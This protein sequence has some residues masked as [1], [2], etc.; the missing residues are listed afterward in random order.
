MSV[1]LERLLSILAEEEQIRR[2]QQATEEA[3][4][5]ATASSLA[6]V[7]TVYQR[8]GLLA[9]VT[10]IW[11][12]PIPSTLIQCPLSSLPTTL[13]PWKSLSKPLQ[14]QLMASPSWVPPSSE[15][16][17][18]SSNHGGSEED[19]WVVE[20]P[21]SML[22]PSTASDTA[23]IVHRP[24]EG[25]L[26]TKLTEYT[27]GVV[28]TSRPF[29]P[30]GF[31]DPVDQKNVRSSYPNVNLPLDMEADPYRSEEAI[32]RS[33]RVLQQGTEA[34]WNDQSLITAPPG[35]DFSVGLTWDQVHGSSMSKK[36]AP[37]LSSGIESSDSDHSI[38]RTS[39]DKQR[40]THGIS[41]LQEQPTS[42]DKP[43]LPKSNTIFTRDF[44]EDDSLFGS[45]SDSESDESDENSDDGD[46]DVDKNGSTEPKVSK[47]V[48]LKRQHAVQQGDD[49]TATTTQSTDDDDDLDTLLAE[50]SYFEDGAF[51]VKKQVSDDVTTNPLKL[52]E[53]VALDRGN[54]THKSWA[55]TQLLPIRN[56]SDWVPNPAMT[57]SFV[58]D[59]FQQQAIA[60][61][62]RSESVFVAAHTSAGKTV[63]M[64]HRMN[65]ATH[66]YHSSFS[67]LY[68]FIFSR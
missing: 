36:V 63:G 53:R 31:D 44:F 14:K 35:V 10:G 9:P 46:D 66:A 42:F 4:R 19:S 50:L 34:S 1:S 16:H 47:A 12:R 39:A 55:S 48:E 56:F 8:H 64:K 65:T 45:S 11:Q 20:V 15:S 32:Q 59:D 58:L 40:P 28:G 38:D 24:L 29:R 2:Q 51:N 68:F 27:R 30:G 57:Y 7:H 21:L 26:S 62:E 61:L 17:S 49:P 22:A 6:A 25:N 5:A 13:V 41:M 18:N 23:G 37:T 3:F 52:A 67:H 43:H 54:T 60:R 33:N